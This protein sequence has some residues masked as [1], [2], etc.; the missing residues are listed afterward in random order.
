VEFAG[1]PMGMGWNPAALRIIG[2]RPGQPAGPWHP[3]VGAT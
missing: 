1:S 3:Y 2:D